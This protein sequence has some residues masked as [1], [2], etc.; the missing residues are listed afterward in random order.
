MGIEGF[1]LMKLGALFVALLLFAVLFYMAKK[2]INFGIRTITAAFLG[3]LLGYFF[4]GQV[5]YVTIFGR[6]YANLLFAIVVPLLFFSI[7]STVV[8]LESIE[9]MRSIGLKTV[10]IL[11][12]HNVLASILGLILGLAFKV[13]VNSNLQPPTGAEIKEVPTLSETIVSFFPDNIIGNMAEGKV[14]PTIIFAVLLGIAVLHLEHR[15]EGEKAIPFM[16]FIHSASAVIFRFVGI[17]IDF[18]PYA[19]LALMA[20]AI[21]RTD[22]ASITPLLTVLILTYIASI[23]HTYLTTGVLLGAFA[24]V[25]PIT[26]FKK[27]YPVQLI[28]FTTQSSVGTIPANTKN[29]TDELGVSE[30]IATFVASLGSSIGMPGCA[31]FWP[32]LSAI[33]TINIMDISYGVTDYITLVLVALAVSLGTVGVP[34]TA[35]ITTTA[36]F[37][38]MGLPVEMVI[39]LSPISMIADMGR[40]AT[41]V[42]A[43]GSSAVIVAASEKELDREQYNR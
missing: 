23:V 26:F 29:L 15:G 16:D 17:I 31:G 42:T 41:N 27:Y 22:M 9:K 14:I 12:L 35:T 36:V 3:L 24:K 28:A 32:V 2:E 30:K 39:L 20:N 21:S 1:T 43:A 10:G 34:G 8:S 5:D 13:G 33:V 40:T 25:N 11:S 38:A 37:A 7:V 6:I 19:V 18:T 4:K